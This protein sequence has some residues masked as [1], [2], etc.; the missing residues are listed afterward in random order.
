M[1]YA[2]ILE[3]SG[4][5]IR[6]AELVPFHS[7]LGILSHE[8]IESMTEACQNF[9]FNGKI[10]GPD[11]VRKAIDRF[12][13]FSITPKSDGELLVNC[14]RPFNKT[15]LFAVWDAKQGKKLVLPEVYNNAA[16]EI[17]KSIKPDY[18]F[19]IKDDFN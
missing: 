16:S 15:F 7:G 3:N 14:A 5:E 6:S 8:E 13:K 1:R 19:S 9:A 11:D 12:D 10:Y 4:R 18:D 17:F 2:N